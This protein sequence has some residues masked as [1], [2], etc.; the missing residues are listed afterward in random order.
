MVSFDRRSISHRRWVPDLPDPLG[1]IAG[2]PRVNLWS[3]GV[4][5][6]LCIDPSPSA[7][8]ELPLNIATDL[9]ARQRSLNSSPGE[10]LPIPLYLT[11]LLPRHV[12]HFC[13][14]TPHAGEPR[15]PAPP[16]TAARP[17]SAP[18]CLLV[19]QD[20]FA[21]L[22]T[23]S[24]TKPQPDPIPRTTRTRALVMRHRAEP[25]PPLLAL[26][27]TSPRPAMVP[28]GLHVPRR[29]PQT[30]RAPVQHRRG[31]W[32]PATFRRRPTRRSDLG[33]QI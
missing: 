2:T 19:P 10:H 4:P 25:P 32:S 20:E 12:G 26:P 9:P 16:C 13:G 17:A 3:L 23:R 28:G 18:T 5:K 15:P 21:L 11:H 8:H 7:A 29:S 27:R 6:T 24:S 22:R 1:L 33:R 31:D 30:R 14:Q